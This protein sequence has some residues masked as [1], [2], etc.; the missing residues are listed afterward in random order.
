MEKIIPLT[1]KLQSLTR[2]G[3]QLTRKVGVK[4]YGFIF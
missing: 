4:F 2:K 1:R 3:K